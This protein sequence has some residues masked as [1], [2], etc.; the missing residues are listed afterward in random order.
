[1]KKLWLVLFFCCL[2]HSIFS[3]QT[4]SAA[5]E[6]YLEDQFYIGIGINFLGN[7][8]ENVV[9]SSLSYSL[10]AGFIKDIPL[11]KS[12]NFGLGLGLGYAANS[13]YS[14]IGAENDTGAILYRILD[15]EE[16]QRNKLETHTVE[17]P[18]EIRWRTSTPVDY[19]FWRIYAGIRL[20]YVFS[21]RS[22][23]VFDM[24]DLSFDNDDI[25]DFQYGL[26]LSFG[27]NTW[28]VHAYYGL[29]QI[30]NDT[31]VLD[32]NEAIE[33]NVLRIGLIFYIL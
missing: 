2:G 27:Y 11:N 13:Y 22:K 23:T 21:G 15:S 32:T 19:K 18:F 30:L 12:R 1:M 24:G 5:L 29:N 10:Q 33:V 20:G 26:T 6:N 25:E 28:N 16:F 17:V 31:A 3:Q 8:P 7:R 4:S 9:Q 14:N